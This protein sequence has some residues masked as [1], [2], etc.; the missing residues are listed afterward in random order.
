MF[1]CYS[2]NVS[3]YWCLKTWLKG[4]PYSCLPSRIKDE[5]K[6]LAKRGENNSQFETQKDLNN[7]RWR[8][9]MSNFTKWHLTHEVL[10][11]YLCFHNSCEIWHSVSATPM[12]NF[13]CCYYRWLITSL[14]LEKCKQECI[15]FKVF[16]YKVFVY[17]KLKFCFSSINRA[18]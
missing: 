10:Q 7:R 3:F 13:L 5:R 18:A 15:F 8:K 12:W 17:W 6:V 4:W 14:A 9:W 11:F 16:W 1:K 2:I